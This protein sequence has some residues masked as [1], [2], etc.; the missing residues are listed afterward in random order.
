V[1]GASATTPVRTPLAVGDPGQP[2]C[3]G[4]S[5]DLV[6]GWASLVSETF[7]TFAIQARQETR[8]HVSVQ[9]RVNSGF[10]VARFT[11]IAGQA[12]LER[13]A[14]VIRS[15]SRDNYVLYVSVT[16]EHELVQRHRR[17]TCSPGCMS[18]ITTAEPFVQTKFGDNDTLYLSMPSAFVDQRL[19]Y[20]ED[21]CARTVG[22]REGLGRLAADTVVALQREAASMS[23]AEFLGAA[24]AAA[25]LVL[26][27]ISGAAELTSQDRSIRASN[28]ARAKRLMRARLGDPD[29]SLS[30]IAREC[31]L[32]LRYLH[33]L[34]RD[35][36]HT[37]REYLQGER[38]QAARALLERSP[39]G[40]N[41]VTDVCMMCGFSTPSQFSTAFKRAFGISPRDVVRSG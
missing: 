18:L 17:A 23:A 27:A 30:D 4:H 24:R 19:V 41:T 2:S 16:G 14:T 33:D 40:T 25:D 21:A 26:L 10:A 36:G 35:G 34:F 22:A 20:S 12:Q 11:T 15:D 31:G 32:S 6:Q 7:C 29:L 3:V 39:A 5:S 13:T 9:S 38:L 8:F 37:A 1:T 28:L